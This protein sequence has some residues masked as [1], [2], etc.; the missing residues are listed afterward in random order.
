MVAGRSCEDR[1]RNRTGEMKTKLLAL[2]LVPAVQEL[3]QAADGP[4]SRGPR[5]GGNSSPPDEKKSAF[6]MNTQS[7]GV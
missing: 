6:Q 1:C 5:F 7:K 4:V 2:S 3:A